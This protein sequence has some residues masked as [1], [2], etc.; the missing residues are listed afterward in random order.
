MDSLIN[1]GG[2]VKAMDGGRLVG[3][4]VTFGGRDM[5]GEY[6]HDKTYYG[7]HGGDGVDTLFHHCLPVKG[8]S[9]E[10]NAEMSGHIFPA[11]KAKRTEQGILFDVIVDMADKYEKQVYAA[12]KAG[13]LGFSTGSPVHTVKYGQGGAIDRWIISELSFT[14]CPSDPRNRVAALKAFIDEEAEYAGL[15]DNAESEP[16]TSTQN[17]KTVSQSID[18]NTESSEEAADAIGR[19]TRSAIALLNELPLKA[20]LLEMRGVLREFD[21]RVT[22]IDQDAASIKSG[23]TLSGASL[24]AMIDICEGM[25]STHG[26]MAE[27]IGKLTE[28]IERHRGVKPSDSTPIN[29]VAREFSR[30]LAIGAGANMSL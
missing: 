27:H 13:K 9:E 10:M 1:Y 17:T 23:R 3:Y 4:G 30:Y 15:F 19:E 24:S 7:A 20:Y 5:E 16:G 6:F 11:A 25:K 22:W 2:A 8:L 21:R 14:P 26:S 28:M 12:A 18:L 29:T